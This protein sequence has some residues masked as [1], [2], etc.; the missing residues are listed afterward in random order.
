MVQYL[1]RPRAVRV[2]ATDTG[3]DLT[4][5][6]PKKGLGR[7]RATGIHTGQFGSLLVQARGPV[8][9]W[10]RAGGLKR[11]LQRRL[12]SGTIHDKLLDPAPQPARAGTSSLGAAQPAA[13]FRR[14]QTGQFG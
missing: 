8:P 12:K 13:K 11:G 14:F 4:P 3:Q 6:Q 1:S 2:A 7:V 9:G 10:Q 5:H